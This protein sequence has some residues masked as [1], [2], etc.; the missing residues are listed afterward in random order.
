MGHLFL[1]DL[2]NNFSLKRTSQIIF[3]FKSSFIKLLCGTV[4]HSHWHGPNVHSGPTCLLIVSRPTACSDMRLVSSTEHDSH[5]KQQRREYVLEKASSLWMLYRTV[6]FFFCLWKNTFS[7]EQWNAWE[8]EFYDQ[9]LWGILHEEGF[10]FK[11]RCTYLKTFDV[12]WDSDL[13]EWYD[14]VLKSVQ[15]V[16]YPLQY[17]VGSFSLS[18]LMLTVMMLSIFWCWEEYVC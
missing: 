11:T 5:W 15:A 6:L 17:T 16:V 13:A 2:K 4:K 9:V 18:V 7:E 3:T 10:M 14:N 12:T 8:S 1:N